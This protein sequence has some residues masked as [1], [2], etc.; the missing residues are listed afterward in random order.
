MCGFALTTL[1]RKG[2]PT[3]DRRPTDDPPAIESPTDDGQNKARTGTWGRVPSATCGRRS[4]AHGPLQT[5]RD[6]DGWSGR[7]EESEQGVAGAP[8]N[9]AG[10][11]TPGAPDPFRGA[12]GPSLS[13][14]GSRIL[15]L[16]IKSACKPRDIP[17]PHKKNPE[18]RAGSNRFGG[19]AVD[20][21]NRRFP[22]PRTLIF[23]VTDPR[24]PHLFAL[25]N[26]FALLF[27]FRLSQAFFLKADFYHLQTQFVRNLKKF[28]I[29][30]FGSLL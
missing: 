12:V 17:P 29:R 24:I 19:A 1:G 28:E 5:M 20:A 2:R 10:G 6:P 11:S 23:S 27:P 7:D 8:F 9:S 4:G 15:G 22:I 18:M 21:K 14:G 13:V 25:K 16:K 30:K 3:D 26:H